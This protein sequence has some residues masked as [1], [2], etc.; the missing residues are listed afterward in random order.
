MFSKKFIVVYIL[1]T[2]VLALYT[3]DC[4]SQNR[5]MSLG[6][7]MVW[8]ENTAGPIAVGEV[9]VRKD[10]SL[11]LKCATQEKIVN[12]LSTACEESH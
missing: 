5:S 9:Y 12:F 10:G 7:L 2:L 1:L 11:Y 8:Q 4:Y 3:W 6:Y